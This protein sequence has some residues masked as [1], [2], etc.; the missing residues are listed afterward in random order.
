MDSKKQIT[1]NIPEEIKKNI[2]SGKYTIYGS[3][4]R[5]KKGII[6]CHLE[7]LETKGQQ[8][9]S[10]NIFVSFNNSAITSLSIISNR[11]R[12]D[13]RELRLKVS[14]IDNRLSRILEGQTNNLISAVSDFEDHFSNFLKKSSLTNEREVFSKGTKAAADLAAHIP[15]Y[16]NDYIG[17][18]NVFHR[19]SPYGGEEYR[20]FLDRKSKFLK[21]ERSEFLR[22]E[23][24]HAYNFVCA[25]ISVINNINILSLCYDSR[26]YPGYEENLQQIR[27]CMLSLL[28]QIADGLGEEGDIFDM[29]YSLRGNDY[30]PIDQIE[31]V[32]GYLNMNIHELILRK[33]NHDSVPKYDGNRL[34][35]LYAI[36]KIIK[37]IDNL[38]MREKQFENLD[39]ND[40]DELK[41]IKQL[42]FGG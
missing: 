8:W 10:P 13:I 21:V 27:K 38:L 30:Y 31:A 3:V 40:L 22:F 4:V 17:S 18:T 12:D 26:I 37:D 20:L 24:S 29:C 19:D 28:T 11:L 6:V 33:F 25:F 7:S 41:Q 2:D 16:I 5:D 34:G 15:N 42:T 14:S 35:S 36:V 23:S 39:L 32:V 9:F 1:V